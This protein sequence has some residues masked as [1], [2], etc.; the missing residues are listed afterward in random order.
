[1]KNMK[2]I[3]TIFTVL[4][5]IAGF[6]LAAPDHLQ[7]R[8]SRTPK[9]VR[10]SQLP[11]GTQSST[12]I[13]KDTELHQAAREGNLAL[14]RT[15]LQ[16][17]ADPNVRNTAGRTVLLEA[18]SV[19]QTEAAR[20]LLHSGANVDA[21][22]SEGRTPLIEAAAQGQSDMA[23][24]LIDSGAD[25]NAIQRG[26]GSALQVA[27]R[28]G[29]NDV[30]AILRQA[31]ARSSGRSVGDTVCVRPWKGDGF[32]GTVESVNKTA[33]QIRVTKII[34]CQN[35]GCSVKA[36]CS[37]GR[38]VSGPN[39]IAVGDVVNTVSWCLTHTGVQP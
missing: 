24:L 3:L 18:V 5:A 19:K 39:G 22:S 32:C 10:Q 35:G 7:A 13:A 11:A 26:S 20:L 12:Q 28:L 37:A 33:F 29:Y 1:M 25:L 15:R 34:G 2:S 31:G 17:G 9:F 30:A 27:E 14:L 21:K 23:R 38:P 8:C 6:A 16:Q 36:D 4:A